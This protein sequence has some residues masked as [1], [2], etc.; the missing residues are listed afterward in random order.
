MR[1]RAGPAG[2]SRAG[3]AAVSRPVPAGRSRPGPA[4][5]GCDSKSDTSD[6]PPW[7]EEPFGIEAVLHGLVQRQRARRRPPRGELAGAGRE[8]DER[9]AEHRERAPGAAEGALQA[10]VARAGAV[11]VS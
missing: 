9:A 5:S 4:V 2:R 8:D 1:S 10:V 6:K 7:G 3:P 11:L